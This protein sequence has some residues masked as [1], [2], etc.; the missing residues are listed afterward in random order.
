M[1]SICLFTLAAGALLSTASLAQGADKVADQARPAGTTSCRT[2]RQGVE[3]RAYLPDGRRYIYISA[4]PLR[5]LRPSVLVIV[6][7][8]YDMPQETRPGPADKALSDWWIDRTHPF[9]F[10][11]DKIK[12][13]YDKQFS[14]GGMFGSIFSS[15]PP[16]RFSVPIPGLTAAGGRF[17]GTGSGDANS[18]AFE[19][20]IDFPANTDDDFS[21]TLPSATF[22]GVTVTPHVLHFTRSEDDSLESHVKC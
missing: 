13:A 20:R 21:L 10:S 3:F 8:N 5:G 1:N 6:D 4:S 2:T 14:V 15:N 9:V 22:D 7:K 18:Y 11:A 19:I 16:G 17:E 12:A